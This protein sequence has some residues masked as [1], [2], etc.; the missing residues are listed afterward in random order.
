VSAAADNYAAP[1]ITFNNGDV[2]IARE[3]SDTSLQFWWA[4]N[5]SS[6]WTEETVAGAGSTAASP[7]MTVD[8]DGVNI[9]TVST[10]SQ[11]LFY[12]ATNGVA[13]WHPE[14]VADL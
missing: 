9:S 10:A 12:W 11:L 5:G 7:S 6:N 13:G 1:S 4:V 14:T 2:N 8:G 3:G